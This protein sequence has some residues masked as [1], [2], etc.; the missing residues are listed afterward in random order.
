[1]KNFRFIGFAA[2]GVLAYYIINQIGKAKKI[3]FKIDSVNINNDKLINLALLY[4]PL[5]INAR[6]ENPTEFMVTI[7]SINLDIFIDQ[8]NLGKIQKSFTSYANIAA[9]SASPLVLDA[10]FDLTK[11]AK[12]LQYFLDYFQGIKKGRMYMKGTIVTNVGIFPVN[13]NIDL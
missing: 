7:K 2:L 6:I 4:L 10:D 5:R 9:K 3:L 13:E 1:M 8:D 11:A 12:S